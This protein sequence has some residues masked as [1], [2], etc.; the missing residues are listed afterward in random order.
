[1][2]QCPDC[3]AMIPDDSAFCDQCG[4]ELKWCPECK[5]P[6]RGLE[7]P[8][9]GSDL[10]P[11]RKY[12][13]GGMPETGAPKVELPETQVPRPQATVAGE[14]HCSGRQRLEAHPETRRVR[15]GRRDVA[16]T[17]RLPLC[18]GPSRLRGAGCGRLD[19]NRQQLHQRAFRGRET[20]QQGQVEER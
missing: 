17:G 3:R 4:R 8:V 15:Q 13:G 2:I 12:L 19:H 16:R 10:I 14:G 1:M 7:C 5:R 9:C 18:F 6:K 11:G 20:G